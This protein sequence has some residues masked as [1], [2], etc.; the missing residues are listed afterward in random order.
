M[1]MTTTLSVG[2]AALVFALFCAWR[3]ARKPDPS[4]GPRLVPWRFMMLLSCAAV[5]LM[6]LHLV[7]VLDV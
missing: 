1:D 4:K 2:G 7:N 6:L 5:F 3:G